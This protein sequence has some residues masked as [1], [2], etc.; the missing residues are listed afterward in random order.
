MVPR[1]WLSLRGTYAVLEAGAIAQFAIST[2]VGLRK[3]TICLMRL[4]SHQDCCLLSTGP[5]TTIPAVGTHTLDETDQ[6]ES[7]W[8]EKILELEG[9]EM[10]KMRSAF[11]NAFFI[12]LSLY[13]MSVSFAS[14]YYWWK[15]VKAHDSFIRA[16]VWSPVIGTFKATHWPYYEFVQRRRTQRPEPPSVAYLTRSITLYQS[17]HPLIKALPSAQDPAK[18][19]QAIIALLQRARAEAEKVDGTELN[20]VRPSLGDMVLDKYLQALKYYNDALSPDGDRADLS[21]GDAAMV[22]FVT[23]MEANSEHAP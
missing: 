6:S 18:D 17:A 15:D 5:E 8:W 2:F 9:R 13:L 10:G 20:S 12:V 22:Q 1:S 14:C 3:V 21:R 7:R 4:K 23:W 11:S 16:A 19:I